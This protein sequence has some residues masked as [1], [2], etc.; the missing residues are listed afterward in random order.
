MQEFDFAVIADVQYA[1]KEAE[2][3]RYY[4]QS[5]AKLLQC[6]EE[7]NKVEP[8]FVVQVGDLIDGSDNSLKD[9]Q[10]VNAVLAQMKAP[11]YHVT[12]NHDFEGLSRSEFM[13]YTGMQDPYYTFSYAGWRFVFLDTMDLAV[14]GGWDKSS[15]NYRKGMIMLEETAD[16]GE[17]FAREWNGGI[18]AEQVAWLREVL[19][20][21]KREGEKV[22]VFGHIPVYPAGDKHNLWNSRQIVDVLEAPGNVAAYICGHNHAG[23][24]GENNGV[25]YM[26]MPAMVDGESQNSYAIV[27]VSSDKL[28]ITGRGAVPSRE[29]AV[30]KPYGHL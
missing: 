1:D 11:V 19:G 26:T 10:N 13:A 16:A 8:A 22:V 3:S 23:S 20:R 2:G 6:A 4:R 15:E 5:M 25:H 17:E 21:A 14:Q 27:H 12:G 7:L 9:L 24:Y 18:G 28:V 30:D 29:I